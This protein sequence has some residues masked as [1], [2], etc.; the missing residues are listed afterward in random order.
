MTTKLADV[1]AVAGVSA[2]TVSRFL[3]KPDV[4]ARKTGER[5]RAAV[6]QLGYLPNLVAGGLATA[7]SRLVAVQI[8]YISNSIFEVTI[9]AMVGELEAAGIN[10]LLGLTGIDLD[11][12][13]A[14][15]RNALS[16]RADAIIMTGETRPETR[17]LLRASD[18]PVLQIWDMPA[19]PIDLVIG[20]NH[21]RIGEE[22]AR[23]LHRRGYQRP[24]IA[25][26]T[27]SRS[28]MRRDG[29]VAGWGKVA[30]TQVTESQIEIPSHFAHARRVFSELKR[31]DARPDAVICGSD[32]LAT[33]LIV[34][35]QSAGLRVPDDLAVVGFGNSAIAGE[36]RPTITS[37]DID[38]ARVARE[39]IRLIRARVA[40]EEPAERRIDVGFRLIARESA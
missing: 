15:I 25:V 32:L 22:I 8:P 36:M 38:G 21:F 3:N 13:D 30:P 19:D 7:K 23:F 12:T 6:D 20:I 31:L 39:A 29:F 2:A 5:I 18:V 1:A 40:G 4:V 34:E 33:G 28:A 9:E 17:E 11:R 37:I 10:V 16:R 27:G 35:A 26:A 24:H 14:F